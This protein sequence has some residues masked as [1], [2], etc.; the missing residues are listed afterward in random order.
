M[1]LQDHTD[2]TTLHWVKAELDDALS[3]ARQALESYVE[4]SRDTYVM[5]TCAADLHQV[6]GTLRMVEL[7]GAAMVVGEM[8]QLVAALI[9]DRVANRDEAYAAL[10]RG[11]MQMPD[12]LERL[13]SGHR[14]VPIV[15]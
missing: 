2:F 7:Y 15:L 11:M 4:D 5:H 10:M 3:K 14:D 6:H 13:Q 8:E 9:S 1:R 12:Y